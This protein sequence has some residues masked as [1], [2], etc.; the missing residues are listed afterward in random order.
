MASRSLLD[1]LLEEANV[2][3]RRTNKPEM[4]FFIYTPGDHKGTR[5]Q[6]KRADTNADL[7]WSMNGREME[8]VL[9]STINVLKL[10]DK[11]GNVIG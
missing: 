7:S 1:S 10:T 4:A 2:E 11:K 5:Y 3:L 6:L 8:R 9:R